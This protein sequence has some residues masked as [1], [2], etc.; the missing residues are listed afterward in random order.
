MVQWLGLGAFT[1][2]AHI[3]SL[4]ELRPLK[5]YSAPKVGGKCSNYSTS[6]PTFVIFF[7]FFPDSESRMGGQQ[8]KERGWRSERKG[9]GRAVALD[10]GHWGLE[11][12]AS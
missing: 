4:I 12:K 7:F 6:S 11:H 10:S 1:A 5:P 3:Q 2:V 8:R 9:L